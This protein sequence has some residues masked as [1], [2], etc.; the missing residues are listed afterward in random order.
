MDTN[1]C[2]NCNNN[3]EILKCVNNNS[4]ITNAK[5]SIKNISIPTTGNILTSHVSNINETCPNI[6]EHDILKNRKSL[7][8]RP[9]SSKNN[10]DLYEKFKLKLPEPIFITD[11]KFDQV[12]KCD[13]RHFAR[14]KFAKVHHICKIDKEIKFGE[15]VDSLCAKIV[16]RRR[17]GKDL[18][19]D[20][21]HECS[22]LQLARLD[23]A[24]FI[25]KLNSSFESKLEFHLI[26]Q[27]ASGGELWHHLIG[28]DYYN[29]DTHKY[30]D[31][32]RLMYQISQGLNWLHSFRIVHLDLKPQNIFLSCNKFENAIPLLGDFGLSRKLPVYKDVLRRKSLNSGSCGKRIV[33]DKE[34]C[35]MDGNVD[36]NEYGEVRVFAGTPDFCA[37]EVLRFNPID[38]SAD[39]FSLGCCFYIMLTGESAFQCENDKYNFE[40]MSGEQKK[41]LVDQS[42]YYNIE[43]VKESYE[44]YIFQE[45]PQTEPLLTSMLKKAPKDRKSIKQVLE[46]E[47]FNEYKN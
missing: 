12:Y 24:K 34:N 30:K 36:V 8:P 17:G 35:E 27:Y 41:V 31:Y 20:I 3:C 37:P 14:G 4:S 11:K 22:I 21:K 44:N 46:N 15:D 18:S 26:L 2:F 19:T 29:P 32:K 1:E 25:I 28:Q 45:N 47:Y 39:I 9:S 33:V 10:N 16:R 40:G 6:S 23:S 38:L 42:I 43:Q 13:V 5:S 7:E